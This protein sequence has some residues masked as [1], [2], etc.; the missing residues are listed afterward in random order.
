M[1]NFVRVV[2]SSLFLVVAAVQADTT[3]YYNRCTF[4]YDEWWNISKEACTDFENGDWETIKNYYNTVSL[5]EVKMR[6]VLINGQW[7]PEEYPV[8]ERL[9]KMIQIAN[10]KLTSITYN[11]K[12][13][14]EE[15]KLLIDIYVKAYHRLVAFYPELHEVFTQWVSGGP[16]DQ[17]ESWMLNGYE[18][19][20]EEEFVAAIDQSEKEINI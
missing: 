20:F 5:S 13:S 16:G 9:P 10:S 17:M 3:K 8:I 4:G 2:L 12:T 18:R 11:C 14:P 19:V 6:L 15:K 1:N 7:C